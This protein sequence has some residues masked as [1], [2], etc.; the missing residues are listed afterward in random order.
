M[1]Q[2]VRVLFPVF[3]VKL[4]NGDFFE[5]GLIEAAQVNAVT[6][7]VGTGNVEG[8]DAASFTKHVFGFVGIKGI[9]GE[10]VCALQ[11]FKTGFGYYQMQITGA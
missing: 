1:S 6:I 4:L 2:H 7:G 9:R 11:Q 5:A 3:T 8:F 10:I